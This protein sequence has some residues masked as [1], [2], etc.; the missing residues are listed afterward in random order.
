M[1]NAAQY[2]SDD[3]ED[4]DG[5]NGYSDNEGIVFAEQKKKNVEDKDSS[6][7]QPKPRTRAAKHD[8]EGSP[9]AADGLRMKKRRRTVEVNDLPLHDEEDLDINGEAVLRFRSRIWN[10]AMVS[11]GPFFYPFC[12][13]FLIN[14]PLENG[15]IKSWRLLRRN[16]TVT[17]VSCAPGSMKCSDAASQIV[18]AKSAGR[19][20]SCP[21]WRRER[22]A[23]G[24]LMRWEIYISSCPL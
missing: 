20:T 6:S 2:H 12:Y 23:P 17:G 13:L 21:S 8:L 11:C 15:R 9:G 16:T 14:L 7:P 18:S 24:L 5:Q 3:S 1:S 10:Q 22:S 19:S 4:S